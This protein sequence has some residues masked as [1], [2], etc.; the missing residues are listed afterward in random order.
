[1]VFF[2]LFYMKSALAYLGNN[3]TTISSATLNEEME[4]EKLFKCDHSLKQ[5][6]QCI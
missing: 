5:K 4:R 6:K 1:M 2:I 3:I